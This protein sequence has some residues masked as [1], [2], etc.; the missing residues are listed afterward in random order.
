[1]A[2]P[3]TAVSGLRRRSIQTVLACMPKADSTLWYDDPWHSREALFAARSVDDWL[4]R[5]A[6]SCFGAGHVRAQLA[7]RRWQAPTR[8][9]VLLH[10]GP[11][12]EEQRVWTG[13]LSAPPGAMLHGLSAAQYDGLRGIT[14]DVLTLVVPGSSR[15]CRKRLKDIAATWPVAIRWSTVLGPADVAPAALPPR[16][17][18]A[19][20]LVD[21]AA[22]RVTERRA[23][24]IVLAGVQ[25]RLVLPSA[26]SDA[27]SRRGRCRNRAIISEAVVDALGGVESLP[28][29]DFNNIVRRQNLPEPRRQQVLKRPDGRYFLDNDWP[30][31]GVRAEIHGIPHFE[32]RN[33]DNDLL[34]QNDISIEGGGLLL[35]SSYATRHLQQKVGDQLGRMLRRRGWT[36]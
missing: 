23:R 12:T 19:R 2:C 16:T 25:Q 21:A 10:N 4:R 11:P 20:S 24:V 13:L 26:L 15:N 3:Q 18:L 31:Y 27:L 22:E 34:R 30:Q 6:D 28:E 35:F 29:S 8:R 17:R 5:A 1:V 9:V 14:P 33:W 7:A 32:V 36:G